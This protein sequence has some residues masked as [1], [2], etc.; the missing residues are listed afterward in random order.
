MTYT[1]EI[2]NTEVA[3]CQTK[4]DKIVFS[5][6]QSGTTTAVITASNGEKHSFNITVRKSNGW[7]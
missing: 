2:A 3:T 1:V 5:G 7:M 6:L 4:G